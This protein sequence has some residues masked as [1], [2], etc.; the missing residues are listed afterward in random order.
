MLQEAELSAEADSE[1][2]PNSAN[3]LL[4]GAGSP[5]AAHCNSG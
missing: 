1:N 2:N 3:A 5:S 4:S